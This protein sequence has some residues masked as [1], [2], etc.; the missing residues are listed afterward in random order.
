MLIKWCSTPAKW[1]QLPL[2]SMLL[3]GA[4][5]CAATAHAALQVRLHQQGKEFE[6]HASTSA[7]PSPQ[8]RLRDEL[9]NPHHI[10]GRSAFLALLVYLCNPLFIAHALTTGGV[11]F[12]S[13][14]ALLH[15]SFLCCKL[16]C[17]ATGLLLLVRACWE[18]GRSE[19]LLVLLTLLPSLLLAW[20]ARCSGA[21]LSASSDH[22]ERGGK[23]KEVARGDLRKGSTLEQ[24]LGLRGKSPAVSVAMAAVDI[25]V[26]GFLMSQSGHTG[27]LAALAVPSTYTHTLPSALHSWWLDW[28]AFPAGGRWTSAFTS[29]RPLGLDSG[30]FWYLE[31]SMLGAYGPY[32]SVLTAAMPLL[33]A[34]PIAW[35]FQ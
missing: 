21:S 8:Q 6:R 18:S 25:A 10:T 9:L 17:L 31:S 28:T 3:L 1:L 15:A 34:L 19:S 14:A 2:D 5:L 26:A 11:S 33:F 23:D 24:L 22:A 29:Q 20:R 30:L 13:Q 35:T 12:L 16:G 27:W 7:A 4:L 32:F